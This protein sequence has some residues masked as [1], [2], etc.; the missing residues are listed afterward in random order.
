VRTF[1]LEKGTEYFVRPA[2]FRGERGTAL[3]DLT[4]TVT[5]TRESAS[6]NFSLPVDTTS[7]TRPERVEEAAFV[8]TAG[9][10]Y[11]VDELRFLYLDAAVLRYESTMDFA[12]L[13]ALVAAVNDREEA[14]TFRVRRD[15]R[16]EEYEAEEGFYEAMRRLAIS[17]E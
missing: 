1:D 11:P 7:A 2:E 15:G 16:I 5:G 14:I 13:E 9:A 17:M 4:I 6:V 3:V 8:T 12:G 10:E